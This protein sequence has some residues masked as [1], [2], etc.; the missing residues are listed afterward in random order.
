MLHIQETALNLEDSLQIVCNIKDIDQ[1]IKKNIKNNKVS[2][3]PF[4]IL[5]IFNHPKTNHYC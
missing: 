1:E 5:M 2:F 4:D 3:Q